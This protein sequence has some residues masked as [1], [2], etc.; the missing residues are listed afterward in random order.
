VGHTGV[1]YAFV[2]SMLLSCVTPV[3]VPES[4]R[5]SVKASRDFATNISRAL[6]ESYLW[7]L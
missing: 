3:Q 1:N 4:N 5:F 7:L 6:V 2:L